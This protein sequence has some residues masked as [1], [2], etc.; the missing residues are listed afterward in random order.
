MKIKL[1]L[2]QAQ[3]TYKVRLRKLPRNINAKSGYRISANEIRYEANEKEVAEEIL[4]IIQEKQVFEFEQPRLKQIRPSK[5]TPNYISV[6]VRN[7]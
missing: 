1:A 2:E 7:M 5:P 6:F 4:R 3:P